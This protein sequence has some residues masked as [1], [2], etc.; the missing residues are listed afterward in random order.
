LGDGDTDQLDPRAVRHYGAIDGDEYWSWQAHSQVGLVLGQGEVQDNESSK[1]Y[2]YLRT[3]LPVVC[4]K[5]VP[6]SWLIEHTG[7]GILVDYGDDQQFCEA[8]IHMVHRSPHLEG[9]PE[10]MA[11]EHS[12]DARAS[13][14]NGLFSRLAKSELGPPSAL[15]AP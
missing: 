9:L 7:A 1:I 3:G 12:W 11:R 15:S 4:D 14:Y 6:N 8:V 13:L 10:Y 2:Y 5:T